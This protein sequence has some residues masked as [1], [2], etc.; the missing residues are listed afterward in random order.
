MLVNGLLQM[1]QRVIKSSTSQESVYSRWD[2]VE[3]GVPDGFVL[4]LLLHLLYTND[5]PHVN[6]VVPPSVYVDDISIFAELDVIH[7]VEP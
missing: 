3:L 4:S 1:R 6:S 7:F 5:V 2:E